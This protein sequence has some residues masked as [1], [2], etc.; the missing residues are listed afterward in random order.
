M[1]G[2]LSFVV[3]LGVAL[4][5]GSVSS[6]ACHAQQ[7][8]VQQS[9]QSLSSAAALQD[10]VR[11]VQLSQVTRA[12]AASAVASAGAP[13]SQ[14]VTQ[15]QLSA[16]LAAVQA[17]QVQA[18]GATATASAG[19]PAPTVSPDQLLSLL[20]ASQP[21]ASNGCNVGGG[22][23]SRALSRVTSGGGLRLP[24]IRPAVSRSRSLSVVRQ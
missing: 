22:S 12:P 23:R 4:L 11:A 24:L 21:V 20:S 1:K 16:L 2:L 9:Q 6:S 8:N 15:Q 3:A 14:G 17:R 5:C 10:L 19:V 18:P 13:A 7:C